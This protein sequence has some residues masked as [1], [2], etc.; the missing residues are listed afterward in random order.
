MKRSAIAVIAIGFVV[1]GWWATTCFAGPTITVGRNVP[2][3]EQVPVD[4]I[5]HSNWSSLLAKHVDTNGYVNYTTW[6]ASAA[7]QRVLDAYI[8]HLSAASFPPN[9]THEARLAFWINAYNAVTVK[10][11]LREYPTTSIRN[12]TAKV[13]GYNIWKD[14]QLLV[15]GRSYSL[16]AIE[17]EVL[18]KM[19]EPRIHFAIVC[20]SIG[21]PRL[22]NEAYTADRIDEQLTVN[23]RAFFADPTKFSA[24]SR[25]GTIQVSPILNW[26]ADDFGSSTA[27]Q[28]KTVAP[29]VPAQAQPLASSGQAR[30]KYLDYDWGLNDQTR[31]RGSGRR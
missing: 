11:I 18:R 9:A 31:V 4:K 3:G 19:G 5:N 2:A 14:L 6:K 29:Y 13:V 1:A 24:D 8:Q 17:H 26:F 25:T 23:T 10:G 30:V 21:C 7:D 20:A 16:E 15:G 28:L 27:A 12:H 22:L